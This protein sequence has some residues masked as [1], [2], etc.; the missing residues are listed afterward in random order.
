MTCSM[1]EMPGLLDYFTRLLSPYPTFSAVV[2]KESSNNYSSDNIAPP[3]LG[4]NVTNRHNDNVIH[5]RRQ[6]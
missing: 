5:R 3:A 2:D 4:N 6:G 1:Y